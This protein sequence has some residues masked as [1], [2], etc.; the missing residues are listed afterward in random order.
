M[1]TIHHV[2][3]FLFILLILSTL[4]AGNMLFAKSKEKELKMVWEV[5]KNNKTSYLIGTAHYFPYSFKTSLIGFIKD[6]NTVI[7]EG[8]LDQENMAK[9]Q[10]AGQTGNNHAPLLEKLESR[11]INDISQILYPGCRRRNPYF[12]YDFRTRKVEDP[13]YELT[14]GKKFWLAFFTL[15][16]SFLEKK[17]WKY[18][19]DLEAYNIAAELK[20][21]IVFLE[22]IEEQI[23]V[24]E[25]LSQ[26]RIVHFLKQA[27]SWN[28]YMRAYV[29][30][31]LVGDL[32]NLKS[33]A[34]DY[35][36][37][38]PAVIDRRDQI[39]YER[40]IS[41]LEDGS[42]VACLGA[43]HIRGVSELLRGDGFEIQKPDQ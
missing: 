26:E 14:K 33:I 6:V 34:R 40:M 25:T 7:F 31:Y 18:S 21:R 27:D 15:W 42:V 29:K 19:V 35:P 20:K 28:E 11:T 43:P 38:T 16:F 9:V 1:I 23:N 17:G 2:E 37:R 13:I 12:L 30:S 32:N 36:N 10:A 5:Q 22:T 8:P 4:K 3:W 41:Y 24:L 39:F